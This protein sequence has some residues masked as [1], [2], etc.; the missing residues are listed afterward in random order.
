MTSAKRLG[1]P[2]EIAEAV[3]FLCSDGAGYMTGQI[4]QVDGGWILT[5]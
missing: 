3:L 2:E 4:L 5:G 1:Q